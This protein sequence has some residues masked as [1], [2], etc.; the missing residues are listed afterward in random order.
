MRLLVILF[1]IIVEISCSTKKSYDNWEVYGGN[2]E[3]NHYSS[4]AAIDTNNVSQLQLAWEYH[5]GDADSMTQIQVNPIIINGVFFGVSPKLKLFALDAKNGKKFWE[6]DPATFGNSEIQGKGYFSMNV[7]RGVA[8]YK[9]NN[10]NRIFYAAGARLFC[11]DANSGKPITNFGNNGFIDLHDGLGERAKNLYVASTTPGTIYKDKIVIGVRVAEEAAAAA[12]YI[13]AYNVHSGKLE[14]TFHTIPYPGETG[15]ESWEDSTAYK[16]IGGANTWA[17]FSMDEKRGIVFAPIGSATYD[18]YGGKRK[19]ANLFAN[20]LVALDIETGKLKWYF[21]TV[22][23]DL[24]DRDLPTAPILTQV[25]KENKKVDVVIQLT[26]TGFAFILDRESGKPIF[27][28]EEKSVPTSSSLLGEKVYPTQPQPKLP[29]PFVRQQFSEKDINQLISIESRKKI[30]QK[31]DSLMPYHLF[32]PP[33]SK[34]TII[35]P[36]YD[37]GAEWGGGA[38]DPTT[39]LLYVNA[40]EM[41]WIL[42]MLPTVEKKNKET[43]LIAGKRVYTNNCVQCHAP[44]LQGAGN[45]PSLIGVDKKYNDASLL[46]LLQSGRRM[47]PAMTQLSDAEKKAVIY[48]ITNNKKE[49]QKPFTGT[50]EALA[51]WYHLPYTSTGYK[52]FLTPEGYPAIDTPW[53]T[54]SAIDLNTGQLTWRKTLGDYPEFKA[55]GIHTGTENYGGTV[56]TAGGLVFIAATS[57]A[58]FRAYNK[59]DGR[60]IWETDLP[61]AGF[62]TPAVYAIDGQQYIAIAC[63]GGKL[64]KRTGDSYR[65]YTVPKK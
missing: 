3:N 47:M 52:K 65:I 46:A 17:G 56:V 15:Y 8:V 4:L 5:C 42:T 50:D 14:W 30:K 12:G 32:Q 33:S 61:A 44:N 51:K 7:C 18:F 37:G 16:Y 57:D 58:K 1:L 23:H 49:G 19:G 22:H 63:G 26:K 10:G 55:R 25:Q 60:L 54:L 36:G 35:F 40:S 62:A 13:R 64:K 28:V 9:A 31:L 2:N 41:P 43:N 59:I 6:F 48:F 29:L 53:G 38:V 11:I 24:W 20:S 45:Y 27:E 39:G 21:Q 34:G